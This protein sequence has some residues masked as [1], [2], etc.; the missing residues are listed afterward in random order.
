M[1]VTKKTFSF[2]SKYD[3]LTIHGICMIPKEPI[4]IFQ[5]VH[6]MCEHKERFL[7][8]MEWMADKGYVALM[9]DNRGHGESVKQP[10]DIGYCYESKEKGYIEDIYAVTRYIRKE[11]PNLP[12]VLYGHSMG[13]LGIRSYIRKHDAAVDGLIVAGCPA[14]NN[15]VKPARFVLKVLGLV[16]GETFRSPYLQNLVV[17]R[18]EKVFK[19]EQRRFAWLSA[20]KEVAEKFEADKLC[21]F[22]YTLNGIMTL[23]NLENITYTGKGFQV[24][25]PELPVL[26]VSGKDDPCYVSEK[27]WKQAVNRMYQLGYKN[28]KQIRYEGL[29]HEIHNEEEYEKVFQDIEAFCNQVVQDKKERNR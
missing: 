21:N 24:R 13:S 29:R 28:V 16:K 15:A 8:F 26:F 11:F 9:H 19:E 2:Q 17:G 27:R 4:G 14:Y 20:K 10:E 6:G 12:L 3:D 23:L 5:M 25:Q 1:V 22:V 18:F 7:P